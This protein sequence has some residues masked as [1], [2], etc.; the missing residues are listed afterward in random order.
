[1]Q[2][3]E[4]M[5]T[6]ANDQSIPT[7]RFD[8]GQYHTLRILPSPSQMVEGRDGIRHDVDIG[9]KLLRLGFRCMRLY[10]DYIL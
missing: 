3:Q 7:V 9:A 4:W 5:G 8:G 1:L 6:R 2:K 10:R